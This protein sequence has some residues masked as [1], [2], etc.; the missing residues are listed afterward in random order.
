VCVR[1]LLPFLFYGLLAA[2]LAGQVGV[3][4][5]LI[6]GTVTDQDGAPLQGATIEAMSLETRVLRSAVTDPRGRYRILFPDGGGR[7]QIYARSLGY[8]GVRLAGTRR[9]EDD[10][11]IVVDVKL[12]AVPV[13]VEGVTVRGNAN[14]RNAAPTPGSTESVQTPDRLARLPVD[15]SDF[16]AIAA[17]AAGVVAVGGTDS[18]AASFSVAGQGPTANVTTL[19]G[20]G[21]GAASVPQD[22]VR[23][24]RVVTN[25]YDVARGQFSGGLVS[26]TTRSGTNVFQ[27]TGNGSLRDPALAWDGEDPTRQTGAVQQFSLGFGGP[28]AKDRLFYF[29]SAQVRHRD[30][31]LLSA[32]TLDP[33]GAERFGLAPDSLDR[34]FGIVAGF[35]VPVN[36]PGSPDSRFGRDLSALFR[37]DWVLTQAHTLSL[38]GD[39]RRSDQDPTRVSSLGT[40]A[41]GGEQESDGGG[42]MLTLSSR[43]G[44]SIINE[45]KAYASGSS[46]DAVGFLALPQARVQVSSDLSDG[47]TSFSTLSFG[48]SAGLPQDGTTKSFEVTEEMSYLPG[49]ASHRIKAGLFYNTSESRQ[50]NGG[51]RYGTFTYNSL[52][53]LENGTPATFTRTLTPATRE[54]RGSTA[55]VYVGDVWRPVQSVQLTFGVRG[56]RSW[57]GGAAAYDAEVDSLF[58][59]R[60]DRLPEE[61]RLSP[62]LGFSWSGL[63]VEVGPPRLTVRGGI[64]EF[65]SPIPLQLA[66]NATASVSGAAETQL[67]CAGTSVPTP[68][69][70]AYL[71]DPSSIPDAC[72]GPP[73][74]S[75][76]G[77][78]TYTLFGPGVE[79]PRAVRTSL[80][81]Q[82]RAGLVGYG[83]E[84]THARGSAQSGY[85]DRNLGGVQFTL[86]G[87][88]GRQVFAP[89][90]EIDTLSGAVALGASRLA[91]DYG[92]V[93]A[94]T[95]RYRN[96]STSVAVSAN[97]IIGRGV[98]FSTSY[99][100]SQ[101]DDQ[102]SAVSGGGRGGS[103][104]IDPTTQSYAPSDFDR[105]HQFVGTIFFPLG[106]GF[107]LTG[108]GRITSGSPFTPTVAGDVNADGARNDRAFIPDPATA[109]PATAAAMEALLADAPARVRDCLA[110]Q[111]GKVAARNSCRGPWQPSLDLQLNYKPRILEQRLTISFVTSNLL[112]GVDR[113]VHGDDDLRGWGQFTRPDQTLLQVQ[114]FDAATSTYRY[115]VNERF[116]GVSGTSGA[117]VMPFQI[118]VQVRMVIGP[119]GP[120]AFGAGGPGGGG[121]D[122]GGAGGGFRLGAPA[123]PGA[124]PA[125]GV[126]SGA[127]PANPF[128]ERFARMMPDPI[129]G[130]QSS[131]VLVHLT[132]DQSARLDTISQ[133]FVAS[134]DSLAK[135][136]REEITRAGPNPDPAVLF[137][138]LRPKLEEGRKLSEAALQQAKAVLTPEQW[139]QLPAEVREPPRGF[140]PGQ[141]G[142]RRPGT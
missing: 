48:G 125:A 58:G 56:E 20:L 65:R 73:T 66:A 44:Q 2:P 40:S 93:L 129:A 89:A 80:G 14:L 30:D 105:R 31:R 5:D 124:A 13:E 70:N 116:G 7:Y 72:A 122:R 132:D 16:N 54:G 104:G 39:W 118:G 92:Q 36:A 37:T 113:L 52:A 108:I 131:A 120:A 55:A 3:S 75:S 11:R 141:G 95:S 90:S 63:A 102:V 130:I 111:F 77:S 86:A 112:A 128:E 50:N 41:S 62:R 57:F 34:F 22:A 29:F 32:S 114:G 100:W 117:L 35:G 15:A 21:L 76:S 107:E 71:F 64:G 9:S 8:V 43:F 119:T 138:G 47:G 69:W 42:V 49:E 133:K 78:P 6:T 27:A 10:D 87:E 109:D 85:I 81:M 26:S 142:G 61:T 110:S 83:I 135:I 94:I 25:T 99:T 97:G 126:A 88:G 46:N 23:A 134:R 139:A 137:T 1:R 96:R 115:E 136:I 38:R 67:F 53:D 51:N 33:S 19:D 74:P 4:T 45:L 79:A 140:G 82:Y 101:S 68:D 91:P 60:T 98:T 59:L 18:T 28:I 12:T 24:T 17:L 84:V 106:K 121:F 123:T 127:P 103:A